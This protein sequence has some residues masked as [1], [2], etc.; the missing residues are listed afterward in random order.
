MSDSNEVVTDPRLEKRARRRFS[1]AEQKR[2]LAEADALDH[3]DKGAWLWRKGLYAGH[4]GDFRWVEPAYWP[5][6]PGS[7][8]PASS[9]PIQVVIDRRR[10]T[11]L[12]Q[13]FG[14]HVPETGQWLRPKPGERY[15]RVTGPRRRALQD[16][17]QGQKSTLGRRRARLR[18]VGDVFGGQ[19]RQMPSNRPWWRAVSQPAYQRSPFRQIV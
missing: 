2:L 18:V 12:H 3:G 8:I 1:V 9:N 6:G 19:S 5:G 7:G 15:S 14:R 10:P 17:H 13:V 11:H 16:T 4:P